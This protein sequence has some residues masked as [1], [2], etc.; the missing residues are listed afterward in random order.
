MDTF[1]RD[2]RFGARALA[3]SPGFTAVAVV[4]LAI[5]IGTLS[6]FYPIVD[7]LV[8]NPLPWPNSE[9]IVGISERNT[10]KPGWWGV[11]SAK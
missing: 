4:T 5:G 2:L 3:R 11:S 10:R 6:A 1:W 7:D 9:R 8:L